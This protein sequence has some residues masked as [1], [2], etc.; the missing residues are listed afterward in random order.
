MIKE[1]LKLLAQRESKVVLGKY[2][3]NMWVLVMV[4][5][6]TFLSIAFS[7]GSM[8]YL[9]DKMNDPFTNWVDIPTDAENK[10]F[11]KFKSA[12]EDNE[13]REHFF[14]K[15]VQS[16]L[17][18][19]RF[20]YNKDYTTTQYLRCRY[21]ADMHCDI[22]NAILTPENVVN[23]CMIDSALLKNNTP[24]VVMTLD[25]I[26]SLGFSLDSLPAYVDYMAE[27]G[28]AENMYGVKL[29]KAT[30]DY[31]NDAVSKY[32]PMPWP[33]L[34]V[35]KR[36][37]ANL[38]FIASSFLYSAISGDERLF[39]I[40]FHP[41]YFESMYFSVKK[42]Y[43]DTFEKNVNSLD[44]A[45]SIPELRPVIA[46]DGFHDNI[47]GWRDDVIYQVYIGD[48]EVSPAVN[49]TVGQMI[50]DICDKISVRRVYH[51]AERVTYSSEGAYLSV[52]FASLDSI[53]AFE[54][55]AKDNYGIRV[56]MTLVNS[57]ENFNAVSV[58]AN[59]LSL[60]MIVFSIV[61]IVMFI[62]NMLQSYFQK[63]KRNMGTFKAFG[64]NSSELIS[65][66]VLIMLVIV[67]A[68]VLI[69]LG[70]SWLS[71]LLLPCM[72]YVKDGGYNYLS[73]WSEKT[74][75]SILIIILSTI[76]TVCV[77]MKRLLKQTPGDLIYDR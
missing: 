14:I 34:A 76:I 29:S 19:S 67:V 37:P 57:K 42:D 25:A 77:V 48:D 30:G 60:A 69:A 3:S 26:E 59:I 6:A 1:Y 47:K 44:L 65:I 32:M 38:D 18:F 46:P 56:D 53:R 73:L 31:E 74:M 4:F 61:C 72:G 17:Y 36:L 40:E 63:V 21:F 43:V 28:D 9:E 49:N 45:D 27:I 16:D 68:A 12:L 51:Y 64:I 66:Y 41:E 62:I 35:V 20:M 54:K 11:E 50:T 70:V 2:Y 23:N 8:I 13:L 7:N 15:N 24:G 58:M 55:Y 33:L 75:W 52:N 10:K 5:I 39:S 22:V 71:E